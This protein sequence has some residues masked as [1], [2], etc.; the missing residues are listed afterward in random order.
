MMGAPDPDS[1]WKG[2]YVH[3]YSGTELKHRTLPAAYAAG[4]Q[5]ALAAQAERAA[6]VERVVENWRDAMR[7][8]G[9]SQV[10][11]ACAA[12]IAKALS[13]EGKAP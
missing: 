12:Q 5:A 9:P 10:L 6:A 2:P 1:T 13:T 11:E 3:W 8:H 4:F 7:M